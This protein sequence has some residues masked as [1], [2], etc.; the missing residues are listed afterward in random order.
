M[1]I[2][3]YKEWIEGYIRAW[4]SNDPDEIGSLFAEDGRYFTGPFEEPWE[5]RQGIVEGWLKNQ[6]EPGTFKFRYEIQ[7]FSGNTGAMQGWTTYLN[8]LKEYS[9]LWVMKFNQQGECYEFT[10]WWKKRK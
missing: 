7:A 4:N 5:G 6:D 1:D 10:E 8:P 9:N 3:D 2:N